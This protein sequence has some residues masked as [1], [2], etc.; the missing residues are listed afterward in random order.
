MAIKRGVSALVLNKKGEV[1]LTQR[2]D[3]QTWAFPGGGMEKGE[4]LQEAVK[5]EI[6]EE[7]GIKIEV[8][9]LAAVYIIDHFLWRSINFFFL[10]IKARGRLKKQKG[11]TLDLRWVKK[12]DLRKFLSERRYQRFLDAFSSNKEIKVQVSSQ[13]P[14][15][16]AKLPAFLWR[17]YLGKWL[18]LVEV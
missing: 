11:E 7:T 14:I 9:R 16:A 5:R 12:Q 15:S 8:K 10:T 3:L 4:S 18:K 6:E 2:Q 13:F 17:R 1:L